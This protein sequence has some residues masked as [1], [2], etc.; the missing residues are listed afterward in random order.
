MKNRKFKTRNCQAGM[1]MNKVYEANLRNI[2]TAAICLYHSGQSKRKIKE[3]LDVYYEE[4][5]PFWNDRAEADILKAKLDD[6]MKALNLS[7]DDVCSTIR[8]LCN[9]LYYTL[10]VTLE[11]KVKLEEELTNILAIFCIQINESFGYGE[12][13]LKRLLSKM[14]EYEGDAIE[15]GRV[16][17][18]Q[19]FADNDGQIADMSKVNANKIK[20]PTYYEAK[21][22]KAEMEAIRKI[23]KGE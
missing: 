23:Q 15:E 2:F 9:N 21:K 6:K 12:I 11:F 10:P 16:L 7:L 17:F 18:E 3:M 5:V 13:R 8:F 1:V 20:Q 19:R 22:I 4:T 14:M